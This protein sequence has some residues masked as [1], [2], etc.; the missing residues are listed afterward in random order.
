MIPVV[1]KPAEASRFTWKKFT[2]LF[3]ESDSV[4]R[5][6]ISLLFRLCGA[7]TLCSGPCGRCAGCT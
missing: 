6:P 3:R 7:F 5:V 4:V 2:K 1:Y